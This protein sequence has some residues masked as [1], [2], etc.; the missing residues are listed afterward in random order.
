MDT[1]KGIAET[2][3]A[4]MPSPPEIAACK[5]LTSAELDVYATEFSRTGFQGA[6]NW[7]RI[8]V[9]KYALNLGLYPAARSTCQPS[10]WPGP[11][12]GCLTWFQAVLKSCKVPARNCGAF[13]LWGAR[14]I[15]S[16]RS[17]PRR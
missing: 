4:Y 14:A 8:G 5:W 6:L 2:I 1:D 16:S 15:G 3:A 12:N 10:L 9:G 11:P 13:S 17:S 7:Y